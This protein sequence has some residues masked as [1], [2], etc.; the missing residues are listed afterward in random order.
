MAIL[1][2]SIISIVV[3]L[4]AG[5]LLSGNLAP[6][7]K[8]Q[9]I[10][11][12]AIGFLVGGLAMALGILIERRKNI[13]TSIHGKSWLLTYTIILAAL[14]AAVVYILGGGIYVPCGVQNTKM[15]NRLTGTMFQPDIIYPPRTG[16]TRDLSQSYG[17]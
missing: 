12:G 9:I 2:Y 16:G 3:I 10:E 8:Q 14:F 11:K 5:A 1:R 6:D 13:V 7:I 17:L 15:C 4:L